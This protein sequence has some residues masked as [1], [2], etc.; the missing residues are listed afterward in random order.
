MKKKPI[1]IVL[2]LVAA[3]SLLAVTAFASGTDY[4]GYEAFKTLVSQHKDQATNGEK[5]A[6]LVGNISIKD[7]GL[8]LVDLEASLKVDQANEAFSGSFIIETDD[9][10]KS[11]DIYGEDDL[12]YIFD[13]ANN[14]FYKV[15]KEGHQDKNNDEDMRQGSYNGDKEMNPAQEELLDFVMGELK[16]DFELMK[17]SDGSQT[18]E[19]ELTKD[20]VPALLNLMI[21]AMGSNKANM[22]AGSEELDSEVLAKYPL[23]SD[24]EAI[25]ADLP[26]ITDNIELD[27]LKFTIT[28]DGNNDF[29]AL[30]FSLTV[31]GDDVQG[32]SHTQE[33]IGE[34]TAME[35]GTS[36]V[37]LAELEGKEI[38]EVDAEEFH[39]ETMN[40]HRK[41]KERK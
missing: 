4:A 12:V 40:M 26:E 14:E 18:I 22:H 19:F 31:T 35:I 34:F 36:V 2:S 41:S 32:I 7:N 33:I 6:S 21:S 10:N 1:L 17:N 28:R 24:L 30:G 11:V 38:I 3:F 5:N 8:T 37:D 9:L 13:E 16:N 23:L 29:K 20:E 39:S 27:Y 15:N 25:K